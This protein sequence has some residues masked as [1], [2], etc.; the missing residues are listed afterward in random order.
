MSPGVVR[1]ERRRRKLRSPT[2][3]TNVP[4]A[5]SLTRAPYAGETQVAP[6]TK[7]GDATFGAR[8]YLIVTFQTLDVVCA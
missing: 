8:R 1:P 4:S 2:V 6:V 7:Q 3:A 5:V